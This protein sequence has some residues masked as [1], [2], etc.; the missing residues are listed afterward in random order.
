MELVAGTLATV[1][2]V[3]LGWHL[4]Q[5]SATRARE[6]ERGFQR[7]ERIR[8]REEE[9]A[10]LLDEVLLSLERPTFAGTGADAAD[11]LQRAYQEWMRGWTRSLPIRDSELLDRYE[12]VGTMLFWAMTAE[13]RGE[14]HDPHLLERAISSARHAI[15]AFRWREAL[16]DAS[17]PPNPELRGLVQIGAKGADYAQLHEWLRERPH[18]GET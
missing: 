1:L 14:A 3:L 18:P 13:H 4:N 15:Q 5:R 9:A 16:P 6:D 7:A 10:A 12:A 11:M 8:E 2:G 17:F